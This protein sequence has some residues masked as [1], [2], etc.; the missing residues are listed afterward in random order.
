[1]ATVFCL[2]TVTWLAMEE[3][4]EGGSEWLAVSP[5]VVDGCCECGIFDVLPP[6]RGIMQG[7]VDE[8]QETERLTLISLGTPKESGRKEDVAPREGIRELRHYP[9]SPIAAALLTTM[10]WSTWSYALLRS[11]DTPATDIIQG[12]C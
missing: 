11:T 8:D 10:L 3:V 6:V 1:M 9:R 12:V 2:L 5:G 4:S 7:D